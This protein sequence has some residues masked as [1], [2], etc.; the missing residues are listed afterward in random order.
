MDSKN[1]SIT[2]YLIDLVATVFLQVSSDV[3]KEGNVAD[4]SDDEE[5]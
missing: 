5:K 1:S 2:T 3:H 4:A